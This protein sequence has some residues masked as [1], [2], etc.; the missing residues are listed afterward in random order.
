MRIK[1]NDIVKMITG[2]DRGKTGKVLHVFPALGRVTVEGLNLLKK[3]VRPR[4]QGEKGETVLV[5]RAVNIANVMLMCPKC[6]KTSRTGY[7]VEGDSKQR[8]C[9]SCKNTLS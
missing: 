7:K 5:P 4:R 3:H 2:K 1:K 8:F 9:K 6:G